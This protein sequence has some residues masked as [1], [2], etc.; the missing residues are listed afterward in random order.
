MAIARALVTDPTLIIVDEPTAGLDT[1]V[2]FPVVELLGEEI[3]KWGKS[4]RW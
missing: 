4:E 2:G 3:A 1:A